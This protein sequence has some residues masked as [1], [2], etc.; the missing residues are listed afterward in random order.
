MRQP[1]VYVILTYATA[2]RRRQGGVPPPDLKDP[3]GSY[4]YTH[5]FLFR[6]NP[7]VLMDPT[8]SYP[9]RPSRYSMDGLDLVV[10]R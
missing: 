8:G 6:V 4:T 10:S 5:R 2:R 9:R 1:D 7:P 3:T